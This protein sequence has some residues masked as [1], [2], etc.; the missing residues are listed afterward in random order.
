MN[1]VGNS[2]AV[3][4]LGLHALTAEGP[5]SIPGRGTKIP[6]AV[7]HGQKK[8]KN[9]NN[10]KKTQN[11]QTNKNLNENCQRDTSKTY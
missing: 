1:K 6:Q 5:G 10:K 7:W 3:Q 2:L 11:K 8:Q 4:W 9:N